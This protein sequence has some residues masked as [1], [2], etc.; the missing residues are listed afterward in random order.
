MNKTEQIANIRL[1]RQQ[2]NEA[3]L[4]RNVDAICA[5]L[6]A[7]YHVVTSAG[8]QSHGVEEQRRRWT[9]RFQADPVVLY[10]RRTKELRLNKFLDA[11]EELGN[12]AGKFTLNTKIIL[13]AGVYSAQWQRQSNGLWLI[14]SE[15]FTSQRSISNHLA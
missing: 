1:Q 3:I 15:I 2:Y 4:N 9:A 14:K 11:A 5:F 7:D 13:I 10:R 12:W 8:T 6:T